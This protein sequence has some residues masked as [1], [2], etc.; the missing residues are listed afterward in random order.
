MPRKTRDFTLGNLRKFSQNDKSPVALST[1]GTT[2]V[3]DWQVI[4]K[5]SAV[6]GGRRPEMGLER[7]GTVAIV[8]AGSYIILV[9]VVRRS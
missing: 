5:N 7:V 4:E 1:T 8:Y 6:P 9:Q 2:K 3:I